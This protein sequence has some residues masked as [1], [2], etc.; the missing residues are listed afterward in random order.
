MSSAAVASVE[1]LYRRPGFLLRRA[2]QVSMALFELHCGEFGLTPP[3]FGALTVLAA[4][5][6]IDQT[7]LGRA[8]G[9][10]K[11]TALHVVRGL[12]ARK[13]VARSPGAGDRRRVAIALTEAG[14]ALLLRART[15]S[16]RASNQLLSPLQPQEQAQFLMLLDRIC[17]EL[18]EVARAPMIK[19]ARS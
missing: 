10:D 11:V 2:H 18:E 1:A 14:T 12:E 3:Q 4:F 9:Y 15:G 6:G 8:L 16:K 5:P 17:T 19:V 7:T 13:L